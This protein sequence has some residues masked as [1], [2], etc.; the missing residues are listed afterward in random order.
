MRK[1]FFYTVS[2]IAI[3]FLSKEIIAQNCGIKNPSFEYNSGCPTSF[4]AYNLVESWVNILPDF[5]SEPD[6]FNESC[7]NGAFGSFNYNGYSDVDVTIINNNAQHLCG[8]VG[9]YLN[10]DSG[11]D[12]RLKEYITQRVDLI[13]GVTY[14]LKIQVAKSTHV[15]SSTLQRDLTFF[16]YNGVIPTTEINLCP[17]GIDSLAAV[18]HSSINATN[19]EFVVNFT[20]AINYQYLVIGANC[21]SILYATATGYIFIDK[22]ELHSISNSSS[23]TPVIKHVSNNSNYEH[24]ATFGTSNSGACTLAQGS[25]YVIDL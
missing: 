14:E 15:N 11:D 10:K 22:V 19:Q 6:Y 16:G 3:L 20:P 12:A 25:H 9:M 13:A 1:S 8:R 21:N 2:L 4:S 23:F 7:P 18:P 24:P 17:V 5:K